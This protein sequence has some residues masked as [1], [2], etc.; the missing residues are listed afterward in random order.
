M[1]PVWLTSV[2]SWFAEKFGGKIVAFGLDKIRTKLQSVFATRNILILGDSQTG[3]SSL[4]LYLTTGKP[5]QI[6]NG[7]I[8]APEK[9][10]GYA[11]VDKKVTV[12]DNQLVVKMDLAGD[13]DMR[14]L[15]K[16]AIEKVRPVGIIYML[17]GRLEKDELENE[18]E[19]IFDD[20]LCHYEGNQ[21]AGLEAIHLF[22]NFVDQWGINNVEIRNKLR[23]I[24]QSFDK[25][26]NSKPSLLYLR[27]GVS[28]TQ[29]SP[30][31]DSWIE[32]DRALF[33]FGSD[34]L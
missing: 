10:S 4:I 32:A 5:Y 30:H 1:I 18:I 9:T 14:S 26:L 7:Q 17:N 22:V 3:K 8:S 34:L 24:S 11:V 2:T 15:W 19:E 21:G 29:F 13:Q 28:A 31:K 20:V 16:M 6:E 25:R 27:V 12:N 33:S 23:K